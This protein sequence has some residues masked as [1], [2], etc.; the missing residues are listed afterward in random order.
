MQRGQIKSLYFPLYFATSACRSATPFGYPAAFSALSAM[1]IN[2][3]A[4]GAANAVAGPDTCG[5]PTPRKRASAS[6]VPDRVSDFASTGRGFRPDTVTATRTVTD[7][8]CGR[9]AAS[10]TAASSFGAQT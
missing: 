4:D 9:S 7:R 1:P 6:F 5:G 2:A 3:P 10:R 8:A